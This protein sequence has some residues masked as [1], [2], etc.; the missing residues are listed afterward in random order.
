MTSH[1]LP[2]PLQTHNDT[3]ESLSDYLCLCNQAL[4][5]KPQKVHSHALQ[6]ATS[7]SD[8][9]PMTAAL[10]NSSRPI[11]PRPGTPSDE[12]TAE[13]ADNASVTNGLAA[14]AASSHPLSS[15]KYS[16]DAVDNV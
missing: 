13:V 16:K 12:R 6:P 9:A 11:T 7:L 10:E 1:W 15:Q 3:A 8:P 2:W 5:Y 14:A 4:D